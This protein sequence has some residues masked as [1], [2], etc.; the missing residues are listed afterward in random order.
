MFGASSELASAMEF[1]FNILRL[2]FVARTPS[3]EARS[4]G[5]RSNVENAPRQR[6]ITGEPATPT[7]HILCRHVAGWTQACN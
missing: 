3:E 1:G 7:F 6:P 2:L 4:P 5:H